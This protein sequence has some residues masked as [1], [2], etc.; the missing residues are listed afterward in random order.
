MAVVAVGNDG[1][2]SVGCGTDNLSVPTYEIVD[3]EVDDIKICVKY[4]L[5]PDGRRVC[6]MS[7]IVDTVAGDQL[8]MVANTLTAHLA[9]PQRPMGILGIVP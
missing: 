5:T 7:T 9:V 1:I 6:S 3:A 4:F 8:R 2:W